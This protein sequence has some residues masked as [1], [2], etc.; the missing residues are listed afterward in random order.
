MSSNKEAGKRNALIVYSGGDDLFVIGS[1]DDIVEF[2][3]DLS[4]KFEKFSQGKLTLSAGIDLYPEKYPIAVMAKKTGELEE[5]SKGIDEK[6]AVTI[7]N[8]ANAYKWKVLD[9]KVIGEKYIAIEKFLGGQNDRG[10]TFIYRI[11]ELFNNREEKINIARLIA[12]EA[13]KTME[14]IPIENSPVSMCCIPN[15]TPTTDTLT[16][17]EYITLN[18]LATT[19]SRKACIE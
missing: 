14:A 19:L 18:T 17:N 8:E 11:L 7:A 1:W 6:N 2:S 5:I 10:N 16:S 13:I 3:I 15:I 4:R 12:R 9:E